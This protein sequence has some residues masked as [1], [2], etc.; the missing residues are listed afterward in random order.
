MASLSLPTPA[1]APAPP[2]PRPEVILVAGFRNP[3]AADYAAYIRQQKSYSIA[4]VTEA[5]DFYPVQAP[6]P[7]SAVVLF[8]G[9]RM[10]GRDRRALVN[11]V[12]AAARGKASY[13]CIVNTF[14]VHLGDRVAADIESQVLE[15][16]ESLGVRTV[17]FRSGHILSRHSTASAWLRLLGSFYPLVPGRV[18][19]CF[20]ES[21][22]LFAAMERER[23]M[24]PGNRSRTF[25]LLG[26]NNPWRVM[27]ARNRGKGFLSIGLTLMSAVL[28]L[29]LIG[30][31]AAFLL[32]LFARRW[33]HLRRWNFDTLKP[34]SFR[35]L[36]ELVNPYNFRHVKVVGYNNGVNHFG[37]K[38]PARTIV[39]TVHCNRIVRAGPDR[40]KADCGCTILKA[41]EFLAGASQELYVI[42]NYSYVCLGTA[43]FVP[44]HGSA[45]DYSTIADTVTR[46]LFYDPESDRMVLAGRGD[47]AFR[48]HLYNLNSS[49]LLLRLQLRVKP[50]SRYFV[51]RQ[52]LEA[53]DSGVLL[54]ALRDSRAA[55][56]EVRKSRAA[57]SA[58]QVNRYYREPGQA[59]APVLELPR[60]SLGRLWDRL[61]ENRLTSFL[62]HALTRYLG[63]HVELFFT[64]EEFATFWN[65][66]ASLPLRKIQLRY[67]QRDGFPHSPF[68]EHDC[69]SADMFMFRKH[70]AV[71]EEYLKKTFPVIRVNPGKHSA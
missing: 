51:H 40:V 47:P 39:S 41:R 65:S 34:R 14:R 28:S 59:Q 45:S 20:V 61:E 8:L 55:N 37:Q 52:D 31:F 30:H 25:T 70:R 66:H 6:A 1:E 46:A 17:V 63:W 2:A 15:R 21:D 9:R 35:E 58:V 19:S 27:L 12:D 64:A 71:F 13:V 48:D 38:F 32:N 42:P 57:S 3:I 62:M 7:I 56:V 24:Y 67:I 22:D 60:D 16:F 53:P 36:L 11:L 29:L 4:I 10:T 54:L 68:R 26:A 43:F 69:I 23:R 18:R 44:I 33:A 5:E 50:K 49:W